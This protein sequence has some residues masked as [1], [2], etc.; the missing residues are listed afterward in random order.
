MNLVKL[1]SIR[2][3]RPTF[4]N[5]YFELMDELGK[6]IWKASL[7]RKRWG[8]HMKKDVHILNLT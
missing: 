4:Q 3:P 6:V 7:L 1:G 5:P 8:I 2:S